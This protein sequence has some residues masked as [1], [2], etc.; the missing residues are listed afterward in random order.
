MSLTNHEPVFRYTRRV[1]YV[2]TDQM[3]VVHHS[4]YVVYMEEARLA[5]LR[6]IHLPYRKLEERG[7]LLPVVEL[8]VRYHRPARLEDLVT[9]EVRPG[10]IHQFAFIL[11]YT[12]LRGQDTLARGW[13]K[14]ACITPQG[15]IQPIP[16]SLLDRL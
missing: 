1:G 8:H 14:L 13:T 11:H 3:G 9:V 15:K 16:P 7:I 10:E 12:I 5:W 2:D 4:V 6:A